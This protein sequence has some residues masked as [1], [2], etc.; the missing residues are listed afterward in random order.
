M[1]EK[2]L[3][4]IEQ[5]NETANEKVEWVNSVVEETRKKILS[6]DAE[7][8][9]LRWQAFAIAAVVELPDW[10]KKEFVGRCPIWE[11]VNPWVAENVLPQM[12][13]IQETYKSYEELLA[14]FSKFYL[15]NKDQADIIVHMWVP[16]EAKLF[17]DA[18]KN[19]NIWDRDG[20]YPLI[21]ISALPEIGTSVDT[22][23]KEHGIEIPSFE[24]WTHNPLYDS[25]AALEAYKHLLA[26]RKAK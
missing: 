20:P 17:I 4:Q 18:H 19:G 13:W 2:N 3:E 11:E 22:Y 5:S 21:D 10:T 15:E 12:K 9:W 23:N 24:W 6:L 14:A 7:T 25:Y 16:V 26:S 8:N 1:E